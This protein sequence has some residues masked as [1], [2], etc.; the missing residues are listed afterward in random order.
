[1]CFAVNQHGTLE[2]VYLHLVLGY[3]KQGGELYNFGDIWVL[4][5]W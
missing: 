1:M 2:A 3:L 5:C 4:E